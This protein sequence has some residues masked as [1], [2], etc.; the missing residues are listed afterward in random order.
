MADQADQAN[1]AELIT[2]FTGIVPCSDLQ[3]R[4]Y[5]EATNW[6]LNVN[7]NLSLRTFDHF[8]SRVNFNL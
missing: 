2:Q 4:F 3:A 1:Q 5:L 8:L 7:I 6:D